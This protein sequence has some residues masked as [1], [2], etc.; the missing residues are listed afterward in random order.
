MWVYFWALGSVPGVYLSFFF[1][2]GQYHTV[3]LDSDS[4]PTL[5]FFFSV[6]LAIW[7]SLPLFVTLESGRQCTQNNLLGF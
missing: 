5:S 7:D 2:F 6:A 3:L 4:P 1:F